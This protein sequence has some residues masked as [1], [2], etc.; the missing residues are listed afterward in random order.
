MSPRGLSYGEDFEYTILKAIEFLVSIRVND[1]YTASSIFNNKREARGG[2]EIGRSIRSSDNLCG[3]AA[4][5]VRLTLLLPARSADCKKSLLPFGRRGG[6]ASGPLNAPCLLS[7]LLGFA[8]G[9]SCSLGRFR[10]RSLCGLACYRL[11][12]DPLSFCDPDVAGCDDLPPKTRV[13][14][15]S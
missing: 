8:G 15:R 10:G 11:A 2:A 7:L 12:S 4:V 6:I 13:H 14:S 1:F 5:L 9:L 3:W